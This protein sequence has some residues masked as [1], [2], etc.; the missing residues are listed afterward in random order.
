MTP[1][2]AHA[3]LQA[4]LA[5]LLA[6]KFPGITVEVGNSERWDRTA[7]TVR[8]AGFDELLPEE[9]FHRLFHSVP[10][11]F[12]K[13]HLAGCVWFELG[14][15]ESLADFLK[16]P[17]SNDVQGKEPEVIQRLAKVG[18]FE[19][20][21]AEL[22]AQPTSRCGGDFSAVRRILAAKKF[23]QSALR[24]ALLVLM[25]NGAFCDCEA[26]FNAQLLQLR[27]GNP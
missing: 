26:L 4:K 11:D 9:R 25:R 18:F 14:S 24:D 21:A 6:R 5:H 7:V 12:Y 19:A 13:R 20:L 1:P 8:W 2:N 23:A 3:Q 17:R 16:L 10:E 27:T 15:R 22:G